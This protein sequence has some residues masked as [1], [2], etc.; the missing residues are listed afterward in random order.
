M[1]ALTFRGNFGS[2]PRMKQWGWLAALA[3]GIAAGA[4]GQAP[5]PVAE[6][7]DPQSASGLPDAPGSALASKGGQGAG[8]ATT[9]SSNPWW[10]NDPNAQS[11]AALGLAAPCPARPEPSGGTVAQAESGQVATGQCPPKRPVLR[12]FVDAGPHVVPMTWRQKG[13][14]A[15]HDVKDPFILLTIAGSSAYFVGTTPHSPYGPGMHGFG[16]SAGT[17]LL[18]DITG[19]AIGT[20]AVCSVF[21]QDPRYFRMPHK[22][23][24][25]RVVHAVG[26]VVIAQGD[27]GRPM[28]NYQNLIT[29]YAASEIANMYVPGLATD[30]AS[31]NERIFSGFLSDPIGLLIAEFLPDVASH[32][33]VNIVIVQRY[34]N[35]ISAQNGPAQTAV[36]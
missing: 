3:M 25:R 6:L 30:A 23:V 7:L 35:Q 27:N 28:P 15:I 4:R 36:P 18:Q 9:E 13:R 24:M 17:S 5:V 19:E 34:I 29:S 14:L 10:M 8:L 32:V 33:H 2:N 1:D 31:T 20:F 22:P 11:P 16:Y 21:H 26:H 12:P